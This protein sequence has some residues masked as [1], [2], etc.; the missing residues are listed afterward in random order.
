MHREDELSS[1]V[2]TDL[3]I[4]SNET[5]SGLQ[6]I[7][8]KRGFHIIREPR[9]NAVSSNFSHLYIHSTGYWE[10]LIPHRAFLELLTF[11]DGLTHELTSCSKQRFEDMA[12]WN[13]ENLSILEIK[14]ENLIID[15]LTVWCSILDQLEIQTRN[16]SLLSY[17]LGLYNKVIKSIS[18]RSKLDVIKSMYVKNKL[19]QEEIQATSTSHS[20]ENLSGSPKGLEEV[21]NHYR[22][23]VS[24]DWKNHFTDV[25]KHIFK[26]NW[27]ELLVQLGSERDLNW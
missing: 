12:Q 8:F 26:E 14:F 9:D 16:R 25:Q 17:I 11:E 2:R 3:L 1:L 10:E 18:L 5:L 6:K 13:Y 22:K 27:G 23:G 15:I 24:G 20:F 7:N 19:T 21:R 4:L